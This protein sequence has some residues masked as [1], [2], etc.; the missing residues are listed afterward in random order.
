MIRA[1]NP[2]IHPP[3][4]TPTH[5]WGVSTDFKSLSRIELS[6]FIQVLLNFTDYEGSSLWGW[7]GVRVGGGKP[8]TH[9]HTCAHMHA[10][11]CMCAHTYIN[12]LNMINMA[13]SMVVA[14]C[15][16]LAC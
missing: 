11:T 5:G 3:N 10:C 7:L 15:N 16:F 12:M 9:A 1:I 13:A 4:Q 2:P 8:H 14:S 6:Q